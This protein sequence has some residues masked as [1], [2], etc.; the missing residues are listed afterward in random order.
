MS[1]LIALDHNL[2]IDTKTLTIIKLKPLSLGDSEEDGVGVL[3]LVREALN[4][5]QCADEDDLMGAKLHLQRGAGSV[6]IYQGG[7]LKHKASVTIT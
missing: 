6:R 7:Q 4:A 1:G 3:D 5:L 2:D